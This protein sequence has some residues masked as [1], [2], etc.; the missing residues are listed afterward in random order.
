MDK[1]KIDEE[2]TREA[3]ALHKQGRYRRDKRVR[4]KN[5]YN[6]DKFNKLFQR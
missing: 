6:T 1:N 5:D 3:K 4:L 2:A